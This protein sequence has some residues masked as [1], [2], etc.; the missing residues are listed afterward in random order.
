MTKFR[1][2]KSLSGIIEVDLM[3][4]VI[5]LQLNYSLVIAAQNIIIKL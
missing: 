2:E 5:V 3:I 4:M 1:R